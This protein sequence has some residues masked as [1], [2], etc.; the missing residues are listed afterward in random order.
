MTTTRQWLQRIRW[1]PEY[2]KE[3]RWSLGRDYLSPEPPTFALDSTALAK[4]VI[5]WPQTY[6]WKLAGN[7]LDDL[8]R[9][10]SRLVRVQ[11]ASI[12]Q[13]SG[14][15]LIQVVYNATPQMVVLDY[16]DYADRIDTTLL[17]R[18]SLYFKMQYRPQG[19][20]A[21]DKILPGGFTNGHTEVY[22]YIP[23][24]RADA[25][26]PPLY[27]V[28]GRFGLEFAREIR[29]RAVRILNEQ[30]EF[31]FEGGLKKVR[32]SRSLQE[33]AR[34][35]I[36]IDLPSN[37]PLC[38]RLMDYFAVGACVIGPPHEAI[39]PEPLED[40]KHIVYTRPD[41]RDLVPLCRY[42]L[43]DDEARETIRRASQQ[44]F[45]Q[46]VHRDQLARYYLHHILM[47]L[48]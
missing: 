30:R 15:V 31:K 17:D 9:G 7:Y 23:F 21:S 36:C 42:Y 22:K 27:D 18:C 47:R 11:E 14:T 13:S 8:R 39:L 38:F 1:L 46:Y 26:R 25:G 44:Y 10:L 34:S 48:N 33:A 12:P 40:R 41:L 4:F 5:R 19:Y 45:D 28:Y 6:E 43:N 16:S 3:F 35:K 37:S 24:A 29:I 32:Y 2:A 20:D